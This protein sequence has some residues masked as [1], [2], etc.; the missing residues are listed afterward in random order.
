MSSKCIEGNVAFYQARAKSLM[1]ELAAVT[2]ASSQV[3]QLIDGVSGEGT[4]SQ[5]RMGARDIVI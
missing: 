3:G 4:M 1:S 5:E 2:L